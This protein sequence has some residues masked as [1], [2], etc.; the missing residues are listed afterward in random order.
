[1][2][3]TSA[4]KMSFF[5]SLKWSSKILF[6]TVCILSLLTSVSVIHFIDEYLQF[7][8]SKESAGPSALS[9][10]IFLM[11]EHALCTCM[12]RLVHLTTPLHWLRRR[13]TVCRVLRRRH[14]VALSVIHSYV[15]CWPIKRCHFHFYHNF[16]KCFHCRFRIWTAEEAR[17]KF[18]ISSQICCPTILR[19]NCTTLLQSY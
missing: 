1:M 12:S 3:A 5:C 7:D 18:T 4:H 6:H 8:C 16:G 13:Y 19:N 17:I 10:I 11:V 9:L 2:E 14:W 15:H